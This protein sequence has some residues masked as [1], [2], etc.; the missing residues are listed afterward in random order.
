MQLLGF[1]YE[2][3]FLCNTFFA[4]VAIFFC[5]F[6]SVCKALF[7]GQAHFVHGID[8]ETKI[9]TKSLSLIT[10]F[11]GIVRTGLG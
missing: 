3:V 1:S 9:N 8:A 2:F 4:F 7:I 11:F 10:Y 6:F 5:F